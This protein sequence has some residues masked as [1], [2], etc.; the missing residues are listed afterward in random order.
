M[1]LFSFLPGNKIKDA[2][3]K[4]AIVI[5]VRTAQEFDFGRVPE[6]INIPVDRISLNAER[7]KNMKRP[8][9]FCCSSGHRSGAAVRIMKEKG[10]KEV[11]N[12]GSWE[13]VLRKI[14][15]L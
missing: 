6:S 4:G 2:L 1:A 13:S 11:F 5:D 9:I 15:R 8:V 10:L 7:I 14:N 3:R 12:G